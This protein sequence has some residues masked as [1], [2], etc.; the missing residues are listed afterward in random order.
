MKRIFSLIIPLL[1][2]AWTVDPGQTQRVSNLS[3]DGHPGIPQW[4]VDCSAD[5]LVMR[6][7]TDGTSVTIKSPG[8]FSPGMPGALSAYAD[9][10][11]YAT[12][13]S[14]VGVGGTVSTSPPTVGPSL[15]SGATHYTYLYAVRLSAGGS[16][17]TGLEIRGSKVYF[18][19]FSYTI[20]CD[21][22]SGCPKTSTWDLPVWPSVPNAA[23]NVCVWWDAEVYSNGGPA[24]NVAFVVIGQVPFQFFSIPNSV[25]AGNFVLCSPIKPS[26]MNIAWQFYDSS[27]TPY[28]SVSQLFLGYQ[29]LS[30]SVSNGD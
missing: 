11:V 1:L 18:K 14:G 26:N 17:I 10:Y 9:A 21:T 7:P 5:F 30:Y 16:M 8:T 2:C 4:V 13:G 24:W 22:L 19:E 12:W 25:V 15:P 20:A 28:S 3:C 6:N 23:H 27:P 29:L